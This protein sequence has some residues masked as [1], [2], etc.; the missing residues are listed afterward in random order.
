VPGERAIFFQNPSRKF[1]FYCYESKKPSGDQIREMVATG[2]GRFHMESPSKQSL[3][4][5]TTYHIFQLQIYK[6][7]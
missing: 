1:F 6:I 5:Y 7:I 4:I 2:F 3:K